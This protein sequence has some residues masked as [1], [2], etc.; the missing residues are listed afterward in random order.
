MQLTLARPWTVPP[1]T[2]WMQRARCALLVFGLLCLGWLTPVAAAPG[3]SACVE[4]HRELA[5]NVTTPEAAAFGCAKCHSPGDTA[6]VPHQNLGFF[7]GG[8]ITRVSKS[9]LICHDKPAYAQNKH[10]GLGAGC[11]GCH[12]AH[13]AQHGR[14][15][16]PDATTLC[17][18]CHERKE[19]EAKF[20]HDPVAGGSCTDCHAVHATEHA[21]LLAE[22]PVAVCLGCHKKVKKSP[23]ATIDFTGKGHPVG[24]EKPGLMNPA[25]PKEPFYCGSCHH[26][27]MANERKLLR[28]DQRSPMGFCQQCHKI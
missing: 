8:K 3:D 24:G 22:P 28:F 12:N 7:K 16:T 4:C 17:F 2:R 15:V 25:N 11:T 27:H 19:F 14:L 21:A 9:C 23:H 26:P 10:A 1:T 6:T 5:A 20:V 13:A 18:T